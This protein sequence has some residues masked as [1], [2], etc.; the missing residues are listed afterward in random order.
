MRGLPEAIDHLLAVEFRPDGYRDGV[1][2]PLW[3]AARERVGGALAWTAATRLL[4]AAAAG[5]TVLIATGVVDPEL[6]PSGETDG[7]PGAA[8]LA[9][10]V[11]QAT[12]A[13]VVVLTEA[14]GLGPVRA[15]LLALRVPETVTASAFPLEAAAAE[16]V[17]ERL[18]RDATA[19]IA[20]EKVGPGRDARHRTA[21]G[22]DVDA[23]SAPAAILFAG[24][25]RRGLLTVGVGDL[26]N[27]LGL[28]DL[29]AT[30]ARVLPQGAL[31]ACTVGSDV[32]VVAACSNWG[33]YGIVAA[34]A[35]RC[36]LPDLMPDAAEDRAVLTAVT[37]A[38]A[39]DSAAGRP[40]MAVDGLPAAVHAAFADLLCGVVTFA[41]SRR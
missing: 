38:G 29:A 28:G 32:P 22:K 26:G 4:A 35:A 13:R 18:L 19:V 24:G 12:P 30:T 9:R 36:R 21:T 7:P 41:L 10:A 2:E 37:S 3:R 17:A 8:V 1:I 6:M 39:T 25:Q 40:A 33:A 16:V 34:L 20:V 11:A 5:G 15:A 31:I 27:E 23:Q 14:A